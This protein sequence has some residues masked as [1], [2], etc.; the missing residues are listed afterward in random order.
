MA[1]G[2]TEEPPP[3]TFERQ[4]LASTVRW[5]WLG[6]YLVPAAILSL[7]AA[8][9]DVL[10]LD[11]AGGVVA[12][13]TVVITVA[14]AVWR[15]VTRYRAWS[16]ELTERQLII[17]R[18]VVFELTRIVP[19]ARVQHVDISSGPL[20]RF[21]GLRQLSIYTAGTREA[22]ASIP[23]LTADRAEELRAALIGS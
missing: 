5:V 10:V 11:T 13:L 17:D 8:Q 1:E 7:I 14:L 9:L 23:G 15:T 4:Q 18:G 3:L 19:R 20:D 16:W 6:G 12:S 21:F 22:D 2:E